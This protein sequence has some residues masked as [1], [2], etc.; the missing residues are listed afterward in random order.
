MPDP[1][2]LA[3]P[4]AKK[5]LAL[6]GGGIRGLITIE[7]LAEIESILR[8]RS[9]NDK[10]VLAD[11]FDYI[12][13]TSTGA[14]IGTLLALGKPVDYIRDTYREFARLIFAKTGGGA[15]SSYIE[16]ATN[17]AANLIRKKFNRQ[18][19]PYAQYRAEPLAKKL[20][21]I[22]GADDVTLC[23]NALRTLLLIVMSNA[24]TDSAWPVSSNPKA[25]YNDRARPNSNATI[26]LWLLVRASTA[27]P[28][29][30]PAQDI[31]IGDKA[32]V[33]VDGGITPYNNPAFQLFLQATL[34][35]YNLCWPAGEKEMLL[36]SIGTGLNPVEN[37][38]LQAQDLDF[39]KLAMTTVAAQFNS[40]VY[41]QDLLCRAFGNCLAGDMLDREVGA[42]VKMP[43]PG[44]KKLFTY[45]RYNAELTRAGLDAM[46]LRDIE[47]ANI[48]KLDS[49]DH[50][51]ELQRVGEAVAKKVAAEHFAD[52]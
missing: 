32:H 15:S 16:I 11:Y 49:V 29:V 9:N 12:A 47:P 10:L 30:F 44:G 40:A 45:V 18:T 8:A 46:G 5:L 52:F 17:V 39:L 22:I 43:A 27:A 48:S 28:T 37:L 6:D 36:V 23:D 2:P 35:P 26:P 50:M 1:D 14:V 51:D 13:G 31:P 41:Q 4:G 24:S 20:I 25:K 21:E 33:F 38:D 42:M 3:S 19:V 7:V 34:P